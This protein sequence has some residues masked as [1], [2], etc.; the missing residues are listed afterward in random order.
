MPKDCLISKI[1]KF[2]EKTNYSVIFFVVN[3][4]TKKL[5]KL[6]ENPE[7][8]RQCQN[9]DITNSALYPLY[10]SAAWLN[11]TR[12][13]TYGSYSLH[14]FP[15]EK[16]VCGCI[17]SALQKEESR[18]LYDTSLDSYLLTMFI[19][20]TKDCVVS[21]IPYQNESLL[22]TLELKR[23][24]SLDY[25]LQVFAEK[26]FKEEDRRF[27]KKFNRKMFL[28]QFAKNRLK[29]TYEFEDKQG[30][31]YCLNLGLAMD[32]ESKDIIGTLFITNISVYKKDLLKTESINEK[33]LQSI[34]HSFESIGYLD[35]D[36][37]EFYYVFFKN[38]RNHRKGKKWTNLIKEFERKYIY[39]KDRLI[40]NQYLDIDYIRKKIRKHD[41]T[42]TFKIMQRAGKTF[43][44]KEYLIIG[45]QNIMENKLSAVI[46]YRDSNTEDEYK[47]IINSLSVSYND[48]YCIDLLHD[49]YYTIYNDCREYNCGSFKEYYK[50]YIHPY[51][52]EDEKSIMQ[53]FYNIDHMGE[54]LNKTRS[55]TMRYRSRQPDGSYRHVQVFITAN[56][57]LEDKV[58]SAVI[59]KVD[60]HDTVVQEENSRMILNQA[61]ESASI[62]SKSKTQFLSRMSHD[63]RT[64][65]NS[66][67][68][69]TGL[70]LTNLHNQEKI[71]GYLNT[72]GE[73]SRHLLGLINEILDISRIESGRLSLN[74]EPVQIEEF[75]N[76][77]IAMIAPLAGNKGIH[78]T[79]S[80]INIKQKHL[81]IDKQRL[82]QL[83]TNLLSNAVKY[84]QPGGH[85]FFRA[86]GEECPS[87]NT[88]KYMFIVEDTGIGMTNEFL[89]K[90]FQPFSRA[91]ESKEGTGIGLTISKSIVDLFNGEIEV[92]SQPGIG[93]KF[94]VV[95]Q[96]Q[97]N[98]AIEKREFD[99]ILPQATHVLE[100]KKIL[101][102]EDNVINVEIAKEII[103]NT[104]A[105]VTT[106]CDGKTALETYLSSEE[107]YF[108]LV[109]MD[110][111][112]PVM[113]GY[114][115]SKAIKSARRKDSK[116]LPII[117]MSANA[118][119]DDIIKAKEF[120][121]VDYLSKPVEPNQIVDI[122][123]KHLVK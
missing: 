38:Q 8:H 74:K 12:D 99:T 62:A 116:H 25:F 82:K 17:V 117:G 95:I 113:N 20:I 48:V 27:F 56:K 89:E 79:S 71:K 103:E 19:N 98:E 63:L 51:V 105:V 91:D 104:K 57:T 4:K 87:A 50:K 84:T 60:V 81:L 35:M 13:Y 52:H 14:I 66:I 42:Y 90:L 100:N 32:V 36:T 94:T 68:G 11:K 114:D 53:E 15:Y 102:V 47:K 112:M 115:A 83:L 3:K 39:E 23:G 97:N 61:I 44:M 69:M 5:S 107:H 101:L 28:Q 64:P 37:E 92:E 58:L 29:I 24:D 120:G 73:A 45:N 77:M 34:A 1:E 110:V 16:S 70:S 86:L 123:L 111:Q 9:L 122:M 80:L 85:V 119:S 67:I 26:F 65:L 30:K 78:F 121:M 106:A 72:I 40:F 31:Y 93:T 108:D 7:F 59:L 54:R 88:S 21:D 33:L 2:Y 75:L 118:F 96:F 46:C 55:L 43:R 109:F 22:K 6:Y 10:F 18:P 49:Y 41:Q 76:Q